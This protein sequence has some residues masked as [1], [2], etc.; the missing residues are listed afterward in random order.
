[1]LKEFTLSE[2]KAIINFTLKYCDT[3][4]K[5]LNSYGFRRVIETFILKLKKDEIIIYNYY[6][7][8]FKTD[9]EFSKSLIEVFKLLTICDTD[10]VLQVNNKYKVFIDNKVLFIELIELLYSFWRSLGRFAVVHNNNLGDGLQSVRFIQATE[11]FNELILSIYRRAEETIMGYQH[12]VYRQLIAGVNAGLKLNDV[13]WNCPVEYAGLQ[14]IPFITSVVFY[15]PFISYSKN[16]TRDGLFTEHQTNPLNNVV[17]NEDEWFLFPAKVGSMLTFVYFHKDYMTQGFGL[18]NLFELAKE[19]EYVG[20]KP[21]MIYL[22]GFND[23]YEEKRTFY[24]KDKANDILIG[25]ANHCDEIDYFGYMKK[26]LLTLH[27]IKQMHS[28]YLPIHGAMV[29]ILLKNGTEAN[30]VIM[31]DSGAGKSESLEAFRT[32]NESYIR[33]MRIIFDDM[34]ILKIEED[35]TIKGYGTEIGAFVRVDDL[36]PSYVFQQLDRGIYMN[37]DKVNARVTIPAATYD[38]IMKGYKV[39]YFLYAN[40]FEDTKEKISFFDNLSDAIEV[41]EAGAR[42]AKGTTSEK[43]LVKSFFANPF[44]PVQERELADSLI[45]KYFKKM[46]EN[47][48]KIGQIYTRLAIP[49]N[50]FSGPKEA[51]EEMFELINKGHE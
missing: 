31:G 43:G 7:E 32:L 34:G 10:E 35:G 44:G 28:G 14:K 26:M 47:G 13:S 38:T 4:Q 42:R 50:E 30:I 15:P 29:N 39:D 25:Y 1:M 12:R 23:G 45:H 51:A 2:G 9:E 41:F 33:H 48:V 3:R 22:F 6:I 36:A 18:A 20:K 37:P 19:S 5:I 46:E 40:N 24:Y 11:L 16:N 49:G 21:D 8:A 17:L 27:N